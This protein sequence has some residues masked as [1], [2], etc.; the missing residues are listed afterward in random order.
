[1]N[2]TEGEA[3]Q[4]SPEEAIH[5]IR[6]AR[7]DQVILVDFDETLFL[8]NSTEAYLDGLRP[9]FLGAL[10]LFALSLLRPWKFFPILRR[11]SGGRDWI[12]VLAGSLLLPWTASSWRRRARSA[13][14]EQVNRELL[15]ALEA[16][17]ATIVVASNGFRFIIEPILRS[18]ELRH[19]QLVACRFWKGYADRAGGKKA[20][21]ERHLG[22]EVWARAIVVTDSVDDAPL[23]DAAERA[24]LVTWP[25]ARFEQAMG[26]VYIPFFYTERVKHPGQKY[27]LKT[28]L[29]EDLLFLVLATVWSATDPLLHVLGLGLAMASF[30]CIYEIGYMENDLVAER[31][32]ADPKLS[33]TYHA[34]KRRIRMLQPW[35]WSIPMGV[36][37]AVLLVMASAEVDQGTF[38]LGFRALLATACWLAVLVALRATFFLYNRANKALRIWMYPVLQ[39]FK[40]FGFLAVASVNLVGGLFLAAQVMARWTLYILYRFSKGEWVPVGQLLRVAF[41]VI[42]LLAV[43]TASAPIRQLLGWQTALLLGYGGLKARRE[44][45]QTIGGFGWLQRSGGPG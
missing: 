17:P 43:A 38:G 4:S 11:G 13:G 44:L 36:P 35:L 12:R 1:M 5:A 30:W 2:W 41:F 10:L 39:A 3:S 33:K 23:L 21:V 20:L 37:G 18:V 8:L 9:R 40:T 29:A 22:S 31:D 6:E 42:L 34:H 16:S 32:E 28:V 26:D 14:K 25:K 27:L 7:S 19:E 24:L 45:R 15:E